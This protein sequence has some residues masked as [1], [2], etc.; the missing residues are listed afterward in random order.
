MRGVT[1]KT[2]RATVLTSDDMHAHNTFE[3]PHAV[4]PKALP[5]AV[6][7]GRLVHRFEPAS[8]TKLELDLS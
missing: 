6:E 3:Q 5:L 7:K 4:E 2:P 1:I 8:V